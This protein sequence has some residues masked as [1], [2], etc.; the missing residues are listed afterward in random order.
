MIVSTIHFGS[1][2]VE[3]L[4]IISTFQDGW[5]HDTAINIHHGDNYRNQKSKKIQ[6]SFQKKFRCAA[7]SRKL[8]LR[9][10]KSFYEAGNVHI[11]KN[12]WR[13]LKFRTSFNIEILKDNA[14]VF[15]H[16][17]QRSHSQEV[18]ISVSSPYSI[19]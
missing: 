9:C 6:R 19:M 7:A 15:P 4:D 16:I 3:S 12:P 14:I 1:M 17:Y 5:L 10:L 18:D 2:L 8:I 11:K 13:S